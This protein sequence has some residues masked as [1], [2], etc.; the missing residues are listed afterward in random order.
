MVLP[1]YDYVNKERQWLLIDNGKE[2][3]AILHVYIACQSSNTDGYLQWNEDLFFMLT[4]E[5]LKLRH[6]GFMIISLGDYNS[7]VGRIPGLEQNTPDTNRNAPMFLNFINQVNLIIIN[8]LPIAKGLFT[9]F[10]NNS[11][12]PGSQSL[13]DYGLVDNEHAHTVTS[14]VIDEN[15]RYDCGSDH[16]L[17]M[18]ILVFDHIPKT[19]WSFHEAIKLSFNEKTD[20]TKYKADLDVLSDSIP[21]HP[22]ESLPS[23]LMLS[24]L[25]SCIKESGKK[26]FNLKIKRRKLVPNYPNKP[27]KKC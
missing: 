15:A 11:G 27:F 20:F 23:N 5:A 2:K 24:H 8:T 9:R 3:C 25:T 14:F 7:R 22:F 18:I 17:L 26:N 12:Q 10:M 6:Q 1:K 21:L 19:K 13:L 16:A 4:Q